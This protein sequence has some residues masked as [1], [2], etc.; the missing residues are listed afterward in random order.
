MIK[1]AQLFPG[2]GSQSTQMMSEL[3]QSFEVVQKTFNTATKVLGFNLWDLIQNDADALNQT[4]NTQVAM[5]AAGYAAHLV[6]QETTDFSTKYF[7]GHSLGEYT[8]LVAAGNLSFEEALILVRKRAE[9][10][11]Q[12]V[13]KGEGAMAAI[14]GLEDDKVIDLC[15]K[16]SGVVEAVNFNSPGQ[17]VISGETEAVTQASTLAKELGAKRALILPVSVP[18]HCSLMSEAA[19]TFKSSVDGVNW[20]MS[21]KKVLHN[22]DMSIAQ[23]IDEIKQK[24]VAQLHK[25][26]L[27]TQTI[28]TLVNQ[29]ITTMIEC[30]PGK[31]LTGLNRRINREINSYPLFDN[32]T[33]QE[34][35]DVK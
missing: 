25:P 8:A 21:D 5:L 31:V 11:S 24:L 16:T 4:Q 9:L 28:E 12:A 18:S 15:Q 2:Q 34:I 29:N 1:I 33:I 23:N 10:M 6:L 27:W 35:K 14:L 22:V 32:K 20:S 7:V 3:Y 30:G 17:V 13:P 26:V 19:Q